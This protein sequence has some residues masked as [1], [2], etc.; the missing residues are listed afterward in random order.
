MNYNLHDE[1]GSG[2]R[3]S[4]MAAL[5]GIFGLVMHERGKLILAFLAMLMNSFLNLLSP[6]FIGYTIDHYVVT[7]QYP[8]VLLFSG[9]L[10][11]MYLILLLT[12]YLQTKLMGGVGQRLLFTLRNA[13]FNKL[14]Q[15]PIAFFNQ[16]KAGDLISR[17]NNDTDKL[18]QF[19]SQ[20][21]TQFISSMV[22]MFGAGV[23]LLI[24]NIQ[25][26]LA[27]LAPALFILIFT[28]VVSPWVKKRN[29]ESL[30]AAGDM[31]AE[32][33]ESLGNFKVI[34]AFN[35]RDYYKKRFQEVNQQNYR[36]AFRAGLANNIFLPIYSFF[37]SIAQLIVLTYGIY[38]I[39]VNEL[40]IGLLVSYLAYVVNFYNPLRQ[41]ASLWSSFQ[42]AMAGW[43]RIARIL[44][45]ETNLNVIPSTGTNS[46]DCLLEFNNVYFSYPNGKEI[47][48]D[49][50]FKLL[51]GKTYALVG[52]T[53]GG[54]T[55][56][57]SLMARLYDPTEGHVFLDGQDIRAYSSSERSKKIG[58]I[59]Q[60]PFLFTGTVGENILYGNELYATY[61]STALH[62]LIKD[63]GLEDLIAV[64]ESGLDTPITSQE[65]G[66]SLGQKQVIAFIRAVLRNPDILILDEATA[67]ID[68]ITE[69]LLEKILR[70]LPAHTTLVIIAHR[71]NTIENAD[72]IFFVNL[73]KVTPA[74]SFAEAVNRLL[75][76]KKNS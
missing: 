75:N 12:S 42:V 43:D 41:L 65:D 15:L 52:P 67:N 69:R 64:F 50:N 63:R 31:S 74:G 22:I 1:S 8:G 53:G 18:N 30:R 20:A 51:R 60:E 66:I 76:D 38:L 59:L 35:R 28:K 57:A 47:L 14:L 37:S 58:F 29:A 36:T 2:K 26:G 13:V 4:S 23:F 39:S 19:F 40:T 34:I 48:H 54:K 68:T 49:I 46:K 10:L 70:K 61:D 3:E 25:L 62:E 73:G 9:I 56:T 71:L 7:K 72:E 16:N 21:L 44:S 55:T 24:I 27:A 5:K 45:L 33:Q 6:F 32:I 11:I 17:I